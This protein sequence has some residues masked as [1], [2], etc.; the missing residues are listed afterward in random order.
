MSD[1]K[2][3]F[4]NIVEEYKSKS[5]RRANFNERYTL[6]THVV[7]ELSKQRKDLAVDVGAGVGTL[8]HV[9][10]EV[11]DSVVS[12][13]GSSGMLDELQR[14]LNAGG[15]S[16]VSL[17]EAR[18]PF[19]QMDMDR[20]RGRADMVVCSSVIEYIEED[21]LFLEQLTAIL[22]DGGYLLISFANRK[23]RYR[24]LLHLLS[25]V[26]M[27]QSTYERHIRVMHSAEDVRML[28]SKLNMK[29]DRLLHYA[30]PTPRVIRMI[31]KLAPDSWAHGM[32][33]AVLRK[34]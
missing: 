10:A 25:Y 2:E 23:S 31:L 33:F 15:H 30:L 32:V 3:F 9:L 12:I 22:A 27:R 29:V 6:F 11:F 19:S 21:R 16:N 5:S 13:D 7:R 8:T 18:F 14:T 28:A 24:K 20:L 17:M 4:D 1:N 34:V 26:G